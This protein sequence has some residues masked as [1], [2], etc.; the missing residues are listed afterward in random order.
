MLKAALGGTDVINITNL[1]R[2]II[3]Q[4]T[5]ARAIV[6]EYDLHPGPAPVE[7]QA[8]KIFRYHPSFVAK[9]GGRLIDIDVDVYDEA[10]IEIINELNNLVDIESARTDNLRQVSCSLCRVHRINFLIIVRK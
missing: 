7:E 9:Q 1:K 3:E 4:C 5:P 2:K 6:I 10:S 8:P